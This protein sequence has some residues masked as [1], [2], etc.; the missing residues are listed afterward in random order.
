MK[1]YIRAYQ[2][3]YIG[4]CSTDA[5]HIPG[6]NIKVSE[7]KEILFEKYRVNP[8]QQRLTTKIADTTIVNIYFVIKVTMT[9]EWPLSFFH[10]K[11]NSKIYLEFIQIINKVN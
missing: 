8:S 5:I 1:V 2:N 11:E 6:N 4:N 9:N 3:P 7:L 10:I